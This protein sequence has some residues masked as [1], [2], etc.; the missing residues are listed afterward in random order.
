MARAELISIIVPMYNEAENIQ[1]FY[2]AITHAIVDL[3]Y[4]FELLFINDGSS[5]NTHNQL[6]KLSK[7]YKAVRPIELARNFGKEI[8]LTAGLRESKG[9][10]AIMI[11]ADLQH[12][13]EL[14]VEFIKKWERGADMVIGVRK[15]YKTSVIKKRTSE[16]FYAVMNR[17]SDTEIVPHS[18]DFRLVDRSVINAFNQFTERNRITRG[19]FDWLGFKRDYIFFRTKE[20]QHGNASYTYK[21][22]FKLGVDSFIGHSLLPLRL[23]GMFGMIIVSISIP[24]ALF[25]FIDRYILANPFGFNFSGSAILAVINL[26]LSGIML[27]CLGFISTY[28]AHVHEEVT[29]RPLYV[30]RDTRQK[31]NKIIRSRKNS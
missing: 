15:D 19:L 30:T 20:R 22:L 2:K 5:D 28:L 10:A 11:D 16:L 13:P 27:T 17:V 29:N 1:P 9:E 8:A 21:K 7:K 24:L 25:I 31:P 12:P 26:L 4:K 6:K 18:T 3:P 23:V 14:I